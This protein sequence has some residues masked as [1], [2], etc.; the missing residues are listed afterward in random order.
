MLLWTTFLFVVKFEEQVVVE[1]LK[2]VVGPTTK[3]HFAL[4]FIKREP[5]DVNLTGAFKNS[6][7][8]VIATAVI[9][10]DDICRVRPVEP[11]IGTGN[12]HR[13][14]ISKFGHQRPVKAI[15]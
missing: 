7:R 5:S 13:N 15:L 14:I 8:D 11:L 3:F 12:S 10:Y 4:L 2:S 1:Y 9:S 6:W